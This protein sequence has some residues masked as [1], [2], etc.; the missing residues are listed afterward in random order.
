[1]A[2][3]LSRTKSTTSCCLNASEYAPLA[4]LGPDQPVLTFNGV[5]KAYLA[6]GFRVGWGILTGQKQ[7]VAEYGEAI[8]KMLRVRLCSNQPSQFAVKAALEGDQGH[9]AATVE[10]LKR[11]RDVAIA[12]LNSIPT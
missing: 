6:P 11:R 7:E 5:S 8:A 2:C 3:W 10:K 4:T 12:L 9:I 1:M